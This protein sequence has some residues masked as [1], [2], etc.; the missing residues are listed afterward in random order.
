VIVYILTGL[1][2]ASGAPTDCTCEFPSISFVLTVLGRA[3]SA[4]C[5]YVQC[6]QTNKYCRWVRWD[7]PQNQVKSAGTFP[8]STMQS[9]DDPTA[10]LESS[11]GRGKE[12]Q[13]PTRAVLLKRQSDC[14]VAI[15]GSDQNSILGSDECYSMSTLERELWVVEIAGLRYATLC[16]PCFFAQ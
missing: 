7:T 3:L 8:V 2:N 5:Y 11:I 14:A 4:I 6:R 1:Y 9:S 10:L 13:S 12:R 15:G 16:L